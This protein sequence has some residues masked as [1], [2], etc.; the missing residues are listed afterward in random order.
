MHTNLG[1]C[2]RTHEGVS[3]T[4]KSAHELIC[5]QKNCSSPCPT[6]ESNPGPSDLNS[7]ALTTETQTYV[8]RHNNYAY[9][10][11]FHQPLFCVCADPTFEFA[12]LFK[13][14]EN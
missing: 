2:Q 12:S 9:Q 7:D 10:F 8:P 1:A 11:I 13:I 14:K 3:G 5:R 6:R 4:N